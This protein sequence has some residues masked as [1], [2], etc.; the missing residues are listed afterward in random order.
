MACTQRECV[1]MGDLSG[2]LGREYL[3]TSVQARKQ[4]CRERSQM[5]HST[6]EASNDRGGKGPRL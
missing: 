4:R 5:V 6:D 2:S 3:R 1:N